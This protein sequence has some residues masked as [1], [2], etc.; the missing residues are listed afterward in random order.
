MFLIISHGFEGFLLFNFVLFSCGKDLEPC[1][2]WI[3]CLGI[4]ISIVCYSG[5]MVVHFSI[6]AIANRSHSHARIMLYENSFLPSTL[7]LG[8]F[9]RVKVEISLPF[10]ECKKRNPKLEIIS[11]TSINFLIPTLF[12][13]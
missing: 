5:I 3:F 6:K 11:H 1:L 7:V 9:F 4:I 12:D 10:S 2:N 13:Q 8:V